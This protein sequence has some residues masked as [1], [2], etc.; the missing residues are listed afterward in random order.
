MA[1]SFQ[2]TGYI[3]TV[4]PFLNSPEKVNHIHPTGTGYQDNP[5]V[6]WIL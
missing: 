1:V 2:A 4:R 3:N 6:G 5:N